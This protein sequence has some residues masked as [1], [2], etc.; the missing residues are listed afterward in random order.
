MQY[1]CVEMTL[2]C[3]VGSAYHALDLLGPVV[4][5]GRP[6]RSVLYGHSVNCHP[7]NTF[8]A[9]PS[10]LEMGTVLWRGAGL[11]R[12]PESP[13]RPCVMGSSPKSNQCPAPGT[14]N[15]SAEPIR[16]LG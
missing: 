7:M 11:L 14:P 8:L 3:C 6:S 1:I 5:K 13:P 16:T 10:S 15:C 2:R 9:S 12:D 4:T